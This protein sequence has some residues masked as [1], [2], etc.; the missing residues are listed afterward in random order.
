MTAA[1]AATVFYAKWEEAPRLMITFET[2]ITG[3]NVYLVFRFDGEKVKCPADPVREGYTFTGWYT[4]E[5]H[6]T[7]FDFDTEIVANI[8]LY[9]KWEEVTGEEE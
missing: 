6:T 8:T 3:I 7:E 9:A 5:A 1:T 2:G 4:D